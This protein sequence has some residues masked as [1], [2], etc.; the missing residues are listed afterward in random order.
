MNNSQPGTAPAIAD[1]SAE[2]CAFL[3]DNILA[4]GTSIQPDSE[5]ALLGVDS[6]SLMELVLFIERRYGLVLAPDALT[7]ENLLSTHNLSVCCAQQ[8]QQGNA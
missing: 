8:L 5:L 3:Q 4:P 6:Y 7:P 1:I 2:L